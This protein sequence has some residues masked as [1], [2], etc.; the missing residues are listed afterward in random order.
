MKILRYKEYNEKLDIKPAN[1]DKLKITVL[2]EL[3]LNDIKFSDLSLGDIVKMK[4]NMVAVLV[5]G[6]TAR[7]I[8]GG[9]G[10]LP[11]YENCF[12]FWPCTVNQYK[13]TYIYVRDYHPY[14]PVCNFDARYDVEKIWRTRE[15]Y[16]FEKFTKDEFSEFFIK[17][18]PEVYAE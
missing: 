12:M 3:P 9:T 8:C 7:E 1:L 5:S 2:K 4:R 16:D 17:I 13:Y 15:K 18:R 6:K 14:F 10:L 11:A